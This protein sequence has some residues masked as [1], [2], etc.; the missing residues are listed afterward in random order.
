MARGITTSVRIGERGVIRKALSHAVLDT[1]TRCCHCCADR[2]ITPGHVPRPG[3][4]DGTGLHAELA[5]LVLPFARTA[6]AGLQRPGGG[7][8]RAAAGGPG[9]RAARHRR[10]PPLVITSAASPG[11]SHRRTASRGGG[12]PGAGLCGRGCGGVG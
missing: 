10:P 5:R 6:R 2:T 8:A 3:G 4:G 12:G 11:H 1:V 7:V 9:H